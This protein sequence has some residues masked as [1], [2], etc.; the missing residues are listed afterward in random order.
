VSASTGHEGMK[1]GCSLID[2]LWGTKEQSGGGLV[3]QKG[4]LMRIIV[5]SNNPWSNNN[6]FGNTFSNLFQGMPDIKIA[7]IYCKHGIPQNHIVDH[8]FQITEKML[9]KNYLARKNLSGREIFQDCNA[10][11]LEH[12]ERIIVDYARKKRWM[13]FFWLREIIW[14]FGRWKSPEL[15]SFITRFNPDIIFKPLYSSVY[16]SKIALFVKGYTRKPMV[17]YATDDVYTWHQFSL[18]P[19]YWIDRLIKRK[20]IR[21]VVKQ[22]EMLYVISDAQKEEYGK[23][24]GKPCKI[25]TKGAEFDRPLYKSCLNDPLKFVFTG[26]V[27]AGRWKSLALIGDSLEKINK[28]GIRAI[29]YIFTETPFSKKM[30]HRL[31]SRSIRVM[32]PVPAREI[33]SI[34]ADADVLVHVESFSL[35]DRLVVRHSFSTKLVDYFHAARCVFAV[36]PPDVAS[37]C[38][39]LKNDSAVVATSEHDVIIQL[40][41]IIENPKVV[42]QYA[43]KAWS[44]GKKNHLIKNIQKCLREDLNNLVMK[45]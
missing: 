2:G 4:A 11:R 25:L 9:I 36:A 33:Q 30:L 41:H 14:A 38:Y 12:K 16:M 24:F 3:V 19:L 23:C 42:H 7:N 40:R 45:E 22:C 37:M 34:H 32:N 43:R 5:L 10:E 44:C 29:L 26:N 31:Q 35:K 1:V 15:I 6:S 18:S 27:S 28:N 13:I 20:F 17:C 39:L 8:H 21:D